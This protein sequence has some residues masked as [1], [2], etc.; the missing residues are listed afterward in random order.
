V[1]RLILPHADLS[2]VLGVEL[3]VLAPTAPGNVT[4]LGF[5]IKPEKVHFRK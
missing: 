1:L 3:F 4:F 2:D 5:I